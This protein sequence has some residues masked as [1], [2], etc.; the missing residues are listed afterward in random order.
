MTSTDPSQRAHPSV[1]SHFSIA[2]HPGKSSTHTQCRRQTLRRLACLFAAGTLHFLSGAGTAGTWTPVT[3]NAPSPSG[4]L[5]LLLSD[6]TV[7]CKSAAGGT[8]YGNAWNRLTPDSTGGYVNGTWTTLTPMADTRLYFSSQVLKDGRV[9]VAGGEY[10][11]GSAKGETYNPLTDTWTSGPALGSIISDGNSEILP[12]GRVLLAL[13]TGNLKGT[14]IFDPVANTWTAGPS[15]LGIHN[16]SAWVKLPDASI[17]MVDRLTTNS[18][19]YIPALNQWVVDATVPVALYDPYGDET[20]AGFLL[21][22]GRA[23]FIG[24]PSNTAFYTP[25]G[26]N[27]PGT[28]AAGPAIPGGRGAPDA[29]G[30]MMP[31]GRILCA[32]SPAPDPSNH[33]PTPTGFFEFDYTTNSFAGVSPPTN[34]SSIPSYENN[35]LILPDGTVLYS[36]QGSPTYYVYNPGGTPLAAGKPAIASITA[37]GDGSFHLT[38]TLLNGISEGAAYG[39]DW[40]MATNYPIVRLTSGN[41]VYYAR[42]YNWSSTGVA[43][44]T[45]PVTTEFTLPANLPPGNYS[46]VAIANGIASDPVSFASGAF[47]SITIPAAAREGDPPVIG[48]VTASIAPAA[49][50]LVSL[51]S[52]N[53]TK[54]TVPANVII[55]AGQ[56]SAFFPV[57]IVDNTLLD[58]T[59]NAAIG[60]TAAGYSP[61]SAVIAVADNDVAS[62]A[63]SAIARTQTIGVPF[64]LTLAAEDINGVLIPT[65]T[66]TT[67]LTA[68]G[69]AGPVP[70]T[71]LVSGTFSSGKWTGNVT[72]NSADA[73]VIITASDGGGH[74][75]ISTAFN[76]TP[77]APVLPAMATFTKGN[78]NSVSW[79]AVAGATGYDVQCSTTY[80]FS[81]PLAT[82]S[83]SIPGYV[84]G[85]LADGAIYFY[86]ARATAAS[87]SSPWSDIVASYQDATPPTLTVTNLTQGVSYSTFH[88]NISV[89]GTASDATS[90]VYIVSV[91]GQTATTTDDF[92]DWSVTVP[93]VAG[94]NLLNV[95]ATD[96]AQVGGNTT[97]TSIS[98]TQLVSTQCDNLPDSWKLAHGLNPNSTDPVNG[99]LGNPTH[100]GF[101]NL[102]KY[103]FNLNPQISATAP[104]TESVQVNPT[105]GLNYM[106]VSYPRLIGALDLTYSVQLSD[107][108]VTWP[109]LTGSTQELSVTPNVD[110]VTETVTVRIIPAVNGTSQMFA[111]IVVTAH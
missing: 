13:V 103:A 111:R 110:G 65:Y 108:L 42:T 4:G 96:N 80:D 39:D 81:A 101:V 66:G 89:Q 25:S 9:F 24:S 43:T 19:R 63:F 21:P 1:E 52:N 74:T 58:G 107:D 104:Y 77:T 93:L 41:K 18:E 97:L 90:G 31:N 34:L 6:G 15:S 20:G 88:G 48:T 91:N 3:S 53:V 16:E 28:W 36:L 45:T 30:A 83:P 22:D 67:S 32:L 99:P 44:G 2:R 59:R 70:I 35:L 8:N 23:F 100:D 37:N 50:L 98:V 5:M 17:I 102:L 47:L 69:N 71:P 11:T 84:F 27:S 87:G 51:S 12:D 14:T 54:A 49:D 68:G 106:T 55:A 40:Q 79:A 105:D 76:V 46:L 94:A 61:G 86:R 33:F 38:G 109:S 85:D 7:M 95:T 62:F 64:L 26:N 78:T 92:A 29:P 72:A 10:G 60:A 73:E 75:G 57:T 82:Q 56:T